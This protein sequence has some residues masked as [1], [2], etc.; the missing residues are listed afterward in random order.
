[1]AV[2]VDCERIA[3]Y[4]EV[5]KPIRVADAVATVLE[6]LEFTLAGSPEPTKSPREAVLN[7]S[8]GLG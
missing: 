6:E 5:G 4:S 1:M 3:A 8:P 2:A 7:A